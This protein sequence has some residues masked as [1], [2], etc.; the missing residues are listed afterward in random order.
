LLKILIIVHFLLIIPVHQAKTVR[1]GLERDASGLS[2]KGNKVLCSIVL[3]S[4]L[5]IVPFLC[6]I[7]VVLCAYGAQV[8][9]TLRKLFSIMVSL[10]L[11]LVFMLM[12]K[13]RLF[14]R[15]LRMVID[16]GQ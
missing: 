1:S 8:Y 5:P 9:P 16:F 6:V 14:N 10:E 11:L 2:K 4:N 15:Y 12:G 7:V 3:T 13:I